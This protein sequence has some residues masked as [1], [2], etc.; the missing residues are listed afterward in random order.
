MMK[1]TMPVSLALVFGLLAA[2]LQGCGPS[3]A[4]ISR[5]EM[6]EDAHLSDSTAAAQAADKPD[7]GPDSRESLATPEKSRLD[8][9]TAM[10]KYSESGFYGTWIS[11]VSDVVYRNVTVEVDW[12]ADKTAEVRFISNKRT[13]FKTSSKWKY[14]DPYYEEVYPNGVIARA[15]ITWVNANKFRFETVP[16][17]HAEAAKKKVVRVFERKKQPGASKI[18]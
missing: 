1:R 13:A 16:R 3:A 15:K 6:Q 18:R 14:Q 9:S 5:Q 12:N 10:S 17:N 11:R 4:Q 2:S 7:P 8:S